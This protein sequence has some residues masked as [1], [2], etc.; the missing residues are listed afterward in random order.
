MDDKVYNRMTADLPINSQVAPDVVDCPIEIGAKLRVIRSVRDDPLAGMLSRAQIDQAQYEAGR[1]W[2]RHHENSEIGGISAID[3]AKEA[4]D[5]GKMAEPITDRQITAFRQLIA[6]RNELGQDGNDLITEILGS[7]VSITDAAIS[8]G[9]NSKDGKAY[10]GRRFRECLEC[11]AILWG[12][13]Q[14]KR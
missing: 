13:A 1:R 9:L 3:P 2:Q 12:F 10:V 5:G 6:A 7:C 11:L 8:R 4:V 14:A